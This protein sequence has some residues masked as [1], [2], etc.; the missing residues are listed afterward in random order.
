MGRN[1]IEIR[2]NLLT[3][4]ECTEAIQWVLSN[5]NIIQDPNKP[6]SGYDY[7][8]LM[9][10]GKTFG[11]S[12][13]P[14]PL[15][16]VANA[17]LDLKESYQRKYPEVENIHDWDVDFI[18]FKYWKSGE[19]YNTWHSEHGPH[20]YSHRVLSFLLCLSD[21]NSYTEFKRHRNV[22][23]KAGRGIIFPA[24]HTHE[25]RGSVC[26]KGLDRFMVGGYFSFV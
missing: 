8:D 19:Y 14:A 16:P 1:F 18:R 25:H 26:K 20:K 17:I 10:K 6:N 24:Y 11:D 9:G 5:K 7:C 23:T 4:K 21:N 15:R 22:R 13:S 3:I 12:F 2:D